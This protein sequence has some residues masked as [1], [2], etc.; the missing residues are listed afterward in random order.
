[1][2]VHICSTLSLG[3]SSKEKVKAEISRYSDAGSGGGGG[4]GDICT[5]VVL[6]RCQYVR[7]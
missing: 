7:S 4:M 5:H 1:M 2:Y 3:V 6:E